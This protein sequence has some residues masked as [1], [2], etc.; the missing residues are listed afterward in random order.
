MADAIDTITS[1]NPSD[2]V[3]GFLDANLTYI[4]YGFVITLAFV[5]LFIYIRNKQIYKFNVQAKKRR[6]DGTPEVSI[7][8]AGYINHK[9]GYQVFRI[10]TGRFKSHELDKLPDT[11]YMKGN[12]FFFQVKDPRTWVQTRVI[13]LERQVVKRQLRLLQDYAGFKAGTIGTQMQDVAEDLVNSGIAEYADDGK[14]QEIIVSDEIYEPI[15]SDHKA[16]TVTK[17]QQA[18]A[19]LGVDA[20]KQVAIFTIGLI[21]LAASFLIAYYLLTKPAG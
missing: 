6:G 9:L 3:K 8:K 17:L 10:K 2:A 15:P 7:F 18:S 19:A 20:T 5:L 21:I 12:T 13:D 4:I 14:P 11:R 1:F 16:I